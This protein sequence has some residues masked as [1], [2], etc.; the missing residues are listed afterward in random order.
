MR[1]TKSLLSES[2]RLQRWVHE[3]RIGFC[4]EY[5]ACIQKSHWRVV[6]GC[7][8]P[9]CLS[10]GYVGRGSLKSFAI[11]WCHG[12]GDSNMNIGL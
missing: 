10:D 3:L 7:S 6:I 11:E 9:R 12:I 4:F 2:Q 5:E 8:V 1:N